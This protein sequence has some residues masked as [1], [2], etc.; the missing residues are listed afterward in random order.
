MVR[1]AE[2]FTVFVFG[3]GH[4]ESTMALRSLNLAC[5]DG[6]NLAAK[7]GGGGGRLPPP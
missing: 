6:H 3:C 7:D 1:G 4:I 5:Y 2:A